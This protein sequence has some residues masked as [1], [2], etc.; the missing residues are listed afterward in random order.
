[1]TP[2]QTNRWCYALHDYYNVTAITDTSG[3]VQE[4]YGYTAFGESRFMEVDYTP[5]TGSEHVWDILYKAQQRDTETGF[6]NYGYRYYLPQLGRWPSRDPIQERGGINLYGFV[7]NSSVQR[8]DFLGLAITI[9]FPGGDGGIVEPPRD[10]KDL[11]FVLPPDAPLPLPSHILGS[12]FASAIAK[13]STKPIKNAPVGTVCSDVEGSGFA[14]GIATVSIN[15]LGVYVSH[16]TK[17]TGGQLGSRVG[18]PEI[19]GARTVPL[20]AID[21]AIADAMVN[22]PKC[23]MLDFS[24]PITKDFQESII[25]IQAGEMKQKQFP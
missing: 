15:H 1:M 17:A 13:I 8:V 21:M 22:T 23:C 4:R 25:W 14:W 5:E 20:H 24:K 18:N 10:L 19:P 2:S 16:T 7:G 9:P 12:A 3:D 6:Y 11:P